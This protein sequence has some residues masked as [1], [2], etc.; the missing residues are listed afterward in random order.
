MSSILA[1]AKGFMIKDVRAVGRIDAMR[2]V[3]KGGA[4]LDAASAS[5]VSEQVRKGNVVSPE[6]KLAQ[7]LSEGE[8]A[9]LDLEGMTNREIGERLFLSEKRVKH[10]VSDIL[11]QLGIARRVEA[12]TFAIGRAAPA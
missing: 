5:A 12:A 9:V 1:G 3:G 4:T 11:G 7:Q 10:H 8:L 6:D 2:T